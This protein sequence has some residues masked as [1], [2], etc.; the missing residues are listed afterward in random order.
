MEKS[1]G[2]GKPS[3]GMKMSKIK[4]RIVEKPWGH[5]EIWA[6]TKDYV[7]K[8]MC[9]KPGTRMSLQ[10]HQKK[11]ETVFVLSGTLRVWSSDSNSDYE[12]LHPGE[13]FHVSPNQVHRFGAPPGK[14]NTL[15]MEVSTPYLED[16]IRLADD[17]F[18]E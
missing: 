6:E 10:Y 5:E 18:R 15:I 12:D 4:S 16:V 13:I 1:A 17:F 14:Y 7:A 8:R 11:E 2:I 9:I 3:R